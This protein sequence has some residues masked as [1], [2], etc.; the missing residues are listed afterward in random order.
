MRL[1]SFAMTTD[2]VRDGSKTVTRRLGWRR[3][4]VGDRLRAVERLPHRAGPEGVVEI[5][6]VE[7]VGVRREPLEAIEAADV[8]AEGFPG[9]TPAAFVGFFCRAMKC[10]PATMVTRIEFRLLGRGGEG[11]GGG[12]DWVAGEC[13]GGVSAQ[14]AADGVGVGAVAAVRDPREGGDEPGAV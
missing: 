7:V 1:M 2:Q 10:E 12:G 6:V 13:A 5:G 4:R 8:G 11:G 14:A 3:L 9:M